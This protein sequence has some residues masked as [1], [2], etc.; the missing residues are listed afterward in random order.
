MMKYFRLAV[1]ALPLFLLSCA[2]E[3]A[4]QQTVIIRASVEDS[5][6][7][8][9]GVNILWTEDDA[10]VVNGA[11]ST[12]VTVS[13]DGK[14]AQFALPVISEPYYA[15][16][17]ASA[18]VE[19]SYRPALAKYG[20]LFLPE[21]QNYVSGS[22]DPAAA[23]MTAYHPTQT[24]LNFSCAVAFL[25]FVIESEHP[26][27][28][29]RIEV[30]AIDKE[31]MSGTMVFD[32]AAG[33]L[34]DG[35]AGKGVVV[36]SAEGIA[37]GSAVYVAIAAKTYASGL[38]VRIVDVNNHYQD[39]KSTKSFQA[40]PGVVYK[41]SVDFAPTG[42]LVEG[43]AESGEDRNTTKILLIGNS[44]N[45]DAT[46][47]L[48]IMLRHEGV[49]NV[50]LTRS[51]HGGYYLVGYNAYYTKADNAGMSW[52]TPGQRFWNGT[53]D[54]T[55][56]LEEIVSEQK[57]DI[58]VLMEYTG[59]S[60]AWTW[61]ATERDAIHGLIEKIRRTSPDAEFVYFQSHC[62]ANGY[63]TLLK[64]FN[65]NVEMFEAA[66]NNNSRHVMDPEE[67]YP[68]T[69]FFSTAALIQSLRT[70]GLNEEVGNGRD[71]MRGDYVHMDYGLTRFAAALLVWK[72][73]ITPLTGIQP[74]DITFRF[75]ESYPYATKFTTPVT[76][77]VMPTIL[78]AVNAAY[79]DPYHITDLSAYTTKPSHTGI[80][81]S[82]VL[83]DTGVD[84]FPVTFPVTFRTTWRGG[85]GDQF[86]W[87]PLCVWFSTQPEA[88][89]TWIP[90]GN[91]PSSE[92]YLRTFAEAEASNLCCPS[93]GNNIWT[94]D[95]FEF[96]IPV[97]HFKAGTT[98]RFS[99][100]FYT[101]QGPCFWALDY[102]D[103]GVWKNDSQD[104]QSWDGAF[105]RKADFALKYNESPVLTKD[106]TFQHAVPSG[107]LRF[108]LRCVDGAIQAGNGA[109]VERD[110]P[111][112][113]S[114]YYFKGSSNVTFS[115][116]K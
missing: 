25:R 50:E 60:H 76:E 85:H 105:T 103:G 31:D 40:E 93:L 84:V 70:S 104:I 67:G 28:I 86:L 59:N 98:V 78:A 112:S 71:M 17:P 24:S 108:R 94:G 75:T 32:P 115:I 36:R 65:N 69:R 113:G 101:R 61:D 18:Y 7:C 111:Y 43:T 114:V 2:K 1:F 54:Y 106:V 22:F 21:E 29:S 49:R 57:Y 19:G 90:A 14:S 87:A 4:E 46:D 110:A 64:Y 66:V 35:K 33:L 63:E 56:S 20:S 62:W 6:T 12:S 80:P 30:S 15:L 92:V 74:E 44:H 83:D 5:R 89:A 48:P 55:S 23:L 72:T 3:A 95:Y 16:Y 52:W 38:R 42:T 47:L 68:F 8:L 77:D 99:A 73:L 91:S 109:T 45:L 81:G 37:P 53:T 97:K 107:F 82:V 96:V 11:A 39:I 27:A 26:H 51:F 58:V 9:D 102:Y 79:A 34:N 88:Y 10:I 116:V 13:P 41:T 100:P